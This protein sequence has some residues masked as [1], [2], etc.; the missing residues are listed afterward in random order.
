MDWLVDSNPIVGEILG[1][2]DLTGEQTATI[3]EAAIGGEPSAHGTRQHRDR[4][5]MSNAEAL[6]RAFTGG[7]EEA[8]AEPL[9]LLHA[10]AGS[11]GALD[12][13]HRP[14]PSGGR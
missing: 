3:R 2:L 9:Q 1:E 14:A 6:A 5:P 12:A 13:A 11:R 8:L 10:D 7:Q 4:R